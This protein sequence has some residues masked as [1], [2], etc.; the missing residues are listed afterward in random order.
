MRLKG[1]EHVRMSD[2]LT[3]YHD[4]ATCEQFHS[5]LKSDL[6]LELLP[7]GKMRTNAPVL[8]MGDFVYNL[9]HLIG[10]DLLSGQRHPLHHKLK[11][12]RIKTI[13]QTVIAMVWQLV[14]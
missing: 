2:V 6:D 10:Q 3:L 12:R 5:E 7:S 11:R 14:R 8:V 9:L 13:I 4:H 1:Y